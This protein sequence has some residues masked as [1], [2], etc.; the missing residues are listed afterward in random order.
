MINHNILDVSVLTYVAGVLV[1]TSEIGITSAFNAIPTATLSM[2]PYPQLFGIG[3]KDRIPV[4]IFYKDNVIGE[5][6]LLFEGEA[7]SFSYSS[8]IAT[9]DITINAQGVMAFL[10]DMQFNFL[11]SLDDLAA[12]GTDGYADVAYQNYSPGI[13]FPMSLFM[14]GLGEASEE[15]LVKFPVDYLDNMVNFVTNGGVTNPS[16]QQYND[17]ALAQFYADYCKKIKLEERYLKVP[18]F[19]EESEVWP[20]VG[21]DKA[22]V[23]PLISGMQTKVALDQL[24]GLASEGVNQGTVIQFINHI[25][26][27][28]EYEFAFYNAPTFKDGKLVCISLKPMLYDA[29]PPICNIL[30]RSQ[31]KSIS[32]AEQVYGIPT[33]IRTRDINGTFARLAQG[34]QS[35]I[36]EYGLVDYY[37]TRKYKDNTINPQTAETQ[38]LSPMPNHLATELLDTDPLDDE[39]YT[40]PWVYETAAP[41]WMSYVGPDAIGGNMKIFK[42]RVL[43]RLLHHKQFEKRTLQVQS[44]FTPYVTAGFP[45]AVFDSQDANFVF[46]GQVLAVNHSISKGDFSTT[47]E[48]GF[49]RLVEEA[50]NEPMVNPIPSIDALTKDPDKMAT[51]YANLLGTTATNWQTVS[52]QRYSEAQDDPF[53]AYTAQFRSIVTMDQYIEFMGFEKEMGIIGDGEEV[54]VMLRGGFLEERRKVS[55][56]I[57][58]PD[59]TSGSKESASIEGIRKLLK[60]IA[61]IEF[62]RTVYMP[63]GIHSSSSKAANTI[64]SADLAEEIKHNF[65]DDQA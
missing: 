65:S 37:P 12:S 4:H 62:N 24:Q 5:Y 42:E 36:T 64:E 25:V 48:L 58:L 23:F 54:P 18:F 44:S 17:S 32:T 34:I 59:S 22:Q 45:G 3:R 39:K 13:V 10:Q 16:L 15:N 26:N 29:V 46:T 20:K 52:N 55:E 49:V 33:R 40:G 41:S 60:T 38:A 50:I 19:D 35:G 61:E 7:T 30:Y 53:K 2:P 43:A 1:P 14:Y 63:T 21:A 8:S 27:Q 47:V 28:L 56:Y 11:H 9:R 51:I 31:V 6:I 57:P